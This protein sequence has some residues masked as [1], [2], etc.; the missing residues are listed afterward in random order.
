MT[1]THEHNPAGCWRQ[2]KGPWKERLA[3]APRASIR[4][5]MSGS[6][7]SGRWGQMACSRGTSCSLCAAS[8]AWCGASRSMCST[9]ADRCLQTAL[10]QPHGAKPAGRTRARGGGRGRTWSGCRG[11]G[12][13]R[14]A[15]R[16]VGAACRSPPGS[17]RAS[18]AGR[19]T[20]RTHTFQVS[21]R[22]QSVFSRS[23]LFK[24]V[25]LA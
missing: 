13:E 7:R 14:R 8:S 5:S 2:A 21:E 17:S 16:G 1:G 10:P 20:W 9:S 22:A 24:R 4:P 6:G 15:S 12:C 19:S 23:D 25:S 3:G 18:A 11:S